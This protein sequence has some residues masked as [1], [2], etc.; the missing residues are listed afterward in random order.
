MEREVDNVAFEALRILK[1]EVCLQLLIGTENL[2]DLDSSR[3]LAGPCTAKMES[4][5]QKRKQTPKQK[6]ASYPLYS[7][8]F[9]ASF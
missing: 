7:L 6:T 5:L 8:L 4:K 3:S 9:W 2:V 1:S